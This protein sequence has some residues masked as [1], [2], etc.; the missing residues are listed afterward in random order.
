MAFPSELSGQAESGGHYVYAK[1]SR[2]RAGHRLFHF[3]YREVAVLSTA[4]SCSL[5]IRPAQRCR[6]HSAYG[7]KMAARKPHIARTYAPIHFDDLDPHRFEDLVRE[8]IYDFKEWQAIEATGRAG[9][10]GRLY[11]ELRCSSGLSKVSVH[12]TPCVDQ[13]YL[14]TALRGNRLHFK[15]RCD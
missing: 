15:K 2:R 5:H 11:R 14:G 3:D 1:F 4:R 10:D 7:L 6:S 12:C 9:S 13:K 8:L